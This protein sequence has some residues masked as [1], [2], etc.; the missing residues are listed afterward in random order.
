MKFAEYMGVY[1]EVK[2]ATIIESIN[3]DGVL[4]SIRPK[5]FNPCG[6]M[7]FLIG[8]IVNIDVGKIN[9]LNGRCWIN[10]EFGE[11]DKWVLLQDNYSTKII[12]E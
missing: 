9:P 4:Y 2:I 8:N 5:N 12:D 3:L 1:M 6:L 10:G 11:P 7:D